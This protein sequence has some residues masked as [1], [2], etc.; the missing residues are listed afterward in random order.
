MLTG[1]EQLGVDTPAQSAARLEAEGKASGGACRQSGRAL[2]DCYQLNP[3]MTKSAIFTGWRDMDA[4]MR[5][6]KLETIK[7]EYPSIPASAAR[8]KRAAEEEAQDE[9]TADKPPA[10]ASDK[11]ARPA[12]AH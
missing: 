4:Y 6:N 10:K 2:E 8:A 11:E 9:K 1:C 5:E 3:K 12:K 7:P